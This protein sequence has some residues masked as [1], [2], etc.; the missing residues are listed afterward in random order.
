[1]TETI[2]QK[3]NRVS[4]IPYDPKYQCFIDHLKVEQ[5]RF[6]TESAVKGEL[7]KDLAGFKR[8]PKALQD[9][10]L[11][12]LGFLVASDVLVNDLITDSILD[13]ITIPEITTLLRFEA[14]MEDIHSV[15]YGINLAAFVTNDTR[16]L[17]NAIENMP[18]V[19][20]KADYVK[21]WLNNNNLAEVV[22]GKI[23]TEAIMFSASFLIID[24]L[25]SL[26]YE[27]PGTYFN[28]QEISIDENSHVI[29][30]TKV[31]LILDNKLSAQ[32]VKEILDDALNVEYKFVDDIV[33]KN[34]PTIDIHKV[35][36]EV[37]H[38]AG[39]AAAAIGYPELYVNTKSQFDFRK[40][41]DLPSK[42]NFFEAKD[43]NYQ[44]NIE[45]GGGVRFDLD[46]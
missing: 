10:L 8:M 15:A 43:L 28:N 25:K 36:E 23:G 34:L 12:V 24:I 46:I 3:N 37:R 27:L 40:K 16:Y 32:R 20:A 19:K 7:E 21:K 6:W 5:T 4:I 33:P 41:R 2:L 30:M 29:T 38:C 1:M 13:K 26:G 11:K 17:F 14:M 22:V 44:T 39:L 45:Q 35:K 31:Y 9:M 18:T 42:A